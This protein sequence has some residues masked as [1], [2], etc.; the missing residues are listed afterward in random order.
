MIKHVRTCL[1]LLN[2]RIHLL[3]YQISY[4]QVADY[5]AKGNWVVLSQ[6]ICAHTVNNLGSTE[7]SKETLTWRNIVVF[8]HYIELLRIKVSRWQIVDLVSKEHIL[9]ISKHEEKANSRIVERAWRTRKSVP[10]VILSHCAHGT[11]WFTFTEIFAFE[12]MADIQLAET[13]HIAKI[14]VKWDIISHISSR[15]IQESHWSNSSHDWTK[16]ISKSTWYF[17]YCFK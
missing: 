1:L 2:D 10:I 9:K 15:H 14:R 6:Q 12:S 3:I 7:H 11:L 16:S 5:A 8:Q 17:P 4:L 13:K